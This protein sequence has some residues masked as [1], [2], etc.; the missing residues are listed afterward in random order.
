MTTSN[1]FNYSM[2]ARQICQAAFEDLGVVA[3]GIT[4]STNDETM[5][6][7]RL[8][9]IA[10]QYQGK[11][12]SSPGMKIH[13]RQRVTL[14]L[15]KGQQR[16]L[17]G[18]AATDARATTSYGR[19]TISAAEAAGQTTLSVTAI[20]DTTTDPGNT[21]T[22]TQNDIIGIEQDD[23]TIFWSTIS[24]TG[25]G[26]TVVI[27]T[28]LDVA[29]SAGNY[30]WW[31]TSRAQRFPLIEYAVIRDENYND[32]PIEIYTDVGQYDVGV[33][34]KYAD[35]DPTSILVEPL[36]ITTRVTLNSQ[37]TDV[38]KTIVLTVLYP[39]EDYDAAT[40]DIAYPQ[41]AMRFLEWELAFALSPS[42]GRWTP[43]MEKNRNEARAMY[44]NLNPENSALYFAPNA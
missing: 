35:G 24:S 22:M 29:A 14:F 36:R 33:A 38:T 13:T 4:I 28:G 41:E 17:I 19:T 25:G 21:I 31:F 5:A 23:G 20:T 39:S 6:L 34:A 1:S 12:D 37:P 27:G 16:Y 9:L 42:V 15:A 2:T 43:Q 44:F 32:S 30:V 11:S 10:K 7:V 40:D 8:N 26:P 3:S 18:P